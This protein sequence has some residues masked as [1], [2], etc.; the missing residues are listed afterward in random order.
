MLRC[1]FT[2]EACWPPKYEK[3][4]SHLLVGCIE[5]SDIRGAR[6]GLLQSPRWREHWAERWDPCP[7]SATEGPTSL[8]EPQHLENEVVDPS[9]GLSL[10][11]EILGRAS[12]PHFEHLYLF[13]KILFNN[14]ESLYYFY[15]INLLLKMTLKG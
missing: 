4:L 8:S 12:T 5:V 11:R 14:I 10:K 1:G 13:K 2:R 15:S 7:C 9:D 6:R 3:L